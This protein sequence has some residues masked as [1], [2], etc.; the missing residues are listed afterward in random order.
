MYL[1]LGYLNDTFIVV[2]NGFMYTFI[3]FYFSVQ[4]NIMNI[5]HI[6]RTLEVY[7]VTFG[8]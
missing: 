5:I 2:L 1:N 7:F 8:E 6:Y 4:I 3:V